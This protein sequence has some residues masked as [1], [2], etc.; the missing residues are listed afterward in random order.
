MVFGQAKTITPTA[1]MSDQLRLKLFK[2]EN[3]AGFDL[4]SLNLQ[5]GRDHGLPLYADWK[6]FCENF[7]TQN[8]PSLPYSAA[9]AYIT[10]QGKLI[11]LNFR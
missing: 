8:F 9:T 11:M 1:V 7:M 4:A 5:R 3:K 6:V 10:N 2:L